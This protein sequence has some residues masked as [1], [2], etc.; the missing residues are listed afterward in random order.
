[1][2]VQRRAVNTSKVNCLLLRSLPCACVDQKGQKLYS[3]TI[4]YSTKRLSGVSNSA[5]VFRMRKQ[6]QRSYLVVNW[7]KSFE[8]EWSDWLYMGRLVDR[9]AS[10]GFGLLQ[11]V[12]QKKSFYTNFPRT[13][14]VYWNRLINLCTI[15]RI[16]SWW[17]GASINRNVQ[18]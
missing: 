15:A 7:L 1:M 3:P 8:T 4:V 13:C 16:K 5:E 12:R 17:V 6:T 11:S 10:K 2:F 18:G 9:R 14:L